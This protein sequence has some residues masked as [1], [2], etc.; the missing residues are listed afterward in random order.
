M[1]TAATAVSIISYVRTFKL[2]NTAYTF[3]LW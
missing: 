3:F 2:L 1:E